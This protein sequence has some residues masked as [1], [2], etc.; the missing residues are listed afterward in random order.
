MSFG[1]PLGGFLVANS[2]TL[3]LTN[4]FPSEES[5]NGVLGVVGLNAAMIYKQNWKDHFKEVR[6]LL[7]YFWLKTERNVLLFYPQKV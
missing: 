2:K 7:S 3:R 4:M 5:L 6:K 1:L